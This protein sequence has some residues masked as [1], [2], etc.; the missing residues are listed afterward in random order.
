[1]NA[2]TKNKRPCRPSSNLTR[3][4]GLNDEIWHLI[5]ACWSPKPSERLSAGQLVQ[6][7]HNLLGQLDDPRPLDKFTISL[8]SVVLHQIDHPFAILAAGIEERDGPP[9]NNS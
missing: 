3:R 8:H 2:V 4:R 1:M 7:L 6:M 9:L 5:E